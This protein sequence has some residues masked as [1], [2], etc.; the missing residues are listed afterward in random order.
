MR[1]SIVF[2]LPFSKASLFRGRIGTVDLLVL[3]S[4]DRLLFILKLYFF[5]YKTTKLDEEV[6]RT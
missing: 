4:S 2:N 1:R 6:N 5:L 3:I